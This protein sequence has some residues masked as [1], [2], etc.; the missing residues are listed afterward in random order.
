M[1]RL[2]HKRSGTL[3][4]ATILEFELPLNR[5]RRDSVTSSSQAASENDS[6]SS[7]VNHRPITRSMHEQHLLPGLNANS[8]S[9]RSSSSSIP[10]RSRSSYSEH[11]PSSVNRLRPSHTIPTSTTS[12]IPTSK[13]TATSSTPRTST[14]STPRAAPTPLTLTPSFMTPNSVIPSSPLRTTA[15]HPPKLSTPIRNF[16]DRRLNGTPRSGLSVSLR[17]ESEA[18]D[19]VISHHSAQGELEVQHFP[20]DDPNRYSFVNQLVLFCVVAFLSLT[21]ISVSTP[22]FGQKFSTQYRSLIRQID[23]MRWDWHQR[24][25]TAGDPSGI[26]DDLFQFSDEFPQ[27]EDPSHIFHSNHFLEEDNQVHTPESDQHQV[28]DMDSSGV[29]IETTEKSARADHQQEQQSQ[30]P[31]SD[32]ELISIESI[33]QYQELDQ[34]EPEMM[35]S[36]EDEQEEGKTTNE[37]ELEQ[38]TS[39][40]QDGQEQQQVFSDEPEEVKKEEPLLSDVQ[41]EQIVT[42]EQE[43]EPEVLVE[44][45]QGEVVSE[46][47][48]E[49]GNHFDDLT[50]NLEIEASDEQELQGIPEVSS[51]EQEEQEQLRFDD[52]QLAEEQNQEQKEE[53]EKEVPSIELREVEQ[54]L[55][56]EKEQQ[57]EQAI[58]DEHQQRDELPEAQEQGDS[59][60]E[61]GQGEEEQMLNKQEQDQ[62]QATVDQPEFEE[63]PEREAPSSEGQEAE[64]TVIG[65]L[66]QAEEQ[67]QEL[68]VLEREEGLALSDEQELE[69]DQEQ[70]AP[71]EHV[72]ELERA[73]EQGQ[74]REV[75]SDE[76]E[77]HAAID[78]QLELEEIPFVE[79]GEDQGQTEA[80]EEQEQEQ[81]LIDA[82]EQEQV[83]SYEEILE[84]E[85]VEFEQAG[86][87]VTSEEQ[88]PELEEISEQDTPSNDH[89]TEEPTFSDE[90]EQEDVA[91]DEE[92]EEVLIDEQQLPLD[93]QEIDPEKEEAPP[94]KQDQLPLESTVGGDDLGAKGSIDPPK[95]EEGDHAF[96]HEQ[97]GEEK[98]SDKKEEEDVGE[99]QHPPMDEQE[100]EEETCREE[101]LRR[102]DQYQKNLPTINDLESEEST[103]ELDHSHLHPEYIDYATYRHGG[104][105][106]SNNLEHLVYTS[107]S[108]LAQA[109]LMSKILFHTGM[110]TRGSYSYD[111]ISSRY[112]PTPGHCYAIPGSVGNITITFQAPVNIRQVGVYHLPM[113]DAVAGS[114]RTSPQDFSVIGWVNKPSPSRSLLGH[115][116]GYHLG[117]FRYD[118]DNLLQPL[119]LFDV[120][121]SDHTPS[122]SPYPAS[123][124]PY[125]SFSS[126]TFLIRSNHGSPDFTCIY[127]L[128]VLGIRSN[129][130]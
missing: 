77:Q 80:V 29:G 11:T 121:R 20:K 9:R 62:E 110:D 42:T 108:Y 14:T 66:Q 64:Q 92:G 73:E 99:Q 18:G 102:A 69:Q 113:G 35:T 2:P 44:Q 16:T 81:V 75:P 15:S 129:T 39:G 93:E 124:S 72:L 30:T 3:T 43:Q 128:Q 61:Q 109:N 84:Q 4:C 63:I 106:Y 22:S 100:R 60:S 111:L 38:G 112:P 40:E 130:T 50:L 7:S 21:Y 25:T 67:E 51:R 26:Q 82:P 10:T 79:Q 1:E 32:E 59:F 45:A 83:A 23:E 118:S 95:S 57:Q 37:Q 107:P 116:V 53:R 98:S 8:L 115:E 117:D 33:V 97:K 88:E 104:K 34:A 49:E 5:T 31:E 41:V 13:R 27:S 28:P 120:K 48:E 125:P 103:Q 12:R 71:D 114:E 19:T 36:H 47:Q 127:R 126:V 70:L 96:A 24:K 85:E 76:Q 78:E 91:S 123:P 90:H 68:E 119:Q 17:S 56:D 52:Q 58:F 74:E 94:S 54:S 86:D 87:E 6:V 101:E 89:R 105:I 65:E 55:V 122:S 46:E